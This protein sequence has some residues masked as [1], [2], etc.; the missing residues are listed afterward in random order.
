M[1]TRMLAGLGN[2]GNRYHL[3]RHNA[4]FCVLDYIANS[5]QA[6][7]KIKPSET[8]SALIYLNS[9]EGVERVQFA[10]VKPLSFMNLSGQ[11]IQ[12]ALKYFRVEPSNML[13]IHDEIE[14]PLGEIRLKEGGGHRGHNGL[15]DI[16]AKVGADF[17][18]L[19]IG[20]GR[21]QTNQEVASYVLSPFDSLEQKLLHSVCEKATEI[22]FSWLQTP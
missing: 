7:W 17:F 14:L 2:P 10:A 3:T 21:P 8:E 1:V 13:V 20:V 16:I 9:T 11:P 15:R 12:K 19:R 6:E 18:R 22:C 5:L 4:G